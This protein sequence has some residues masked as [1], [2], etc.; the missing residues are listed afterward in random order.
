MLN[1]KYSISFFGDCFSV[2]VS[3]AAATALLFLN[4]LHDRTIQEILQERVESKRND[5]ERVKRRN[6]LLAHAAALRYLI[7][8][9]LC[10]GGGDGGGGGGGFLP[11]GTLRIATE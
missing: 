1:Q 6:H 11:F 7:P 2:F 10:G 8:L 5:K 9:F 3:T 4:R